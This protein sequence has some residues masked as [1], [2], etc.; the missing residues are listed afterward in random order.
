MSFGVDADRALNGHLEPGER[1]DVIVTYSSGSEAYTEVV[2]AGAAV[3]ESDEGDGGALRTSGRIVLTLALPEGSDVLAL[4]HAVRV[5]DV[6]VV[7]TTGTPGADDPG[8]Y[9]PA[10]PVGDEGGEKP[11]EG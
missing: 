8:A 9:R 1:V 2:V 7:R 6:T 11:D 10:A 3:V 5:G 4:A